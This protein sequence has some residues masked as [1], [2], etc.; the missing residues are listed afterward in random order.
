MDYSY[1]MRINHS[2]NKNYKLY[3]YLL[4]FVAMTFY[5]FFAFYDG[6]V[7]CA[8]TE[9]Y[10]D[11]SIT[12]EFFYSSFLAV[13]RIIFGEQYLLMVVMVQSLLAAYAAWNITV[14]FRTKFELG[15]FLSSV[16]FFI[17]IATSLLNRFVAGRG[18]MYSNS[19]L[20]EGITIPLFL[21]FFRY[22]YEYFSTA[23]KKVLVISGILVWIMIAT[24]KQMYV[25]LFLFFCMMVIVQ[26]M[27]V[28]RGKNLGSFL[29]LRGRL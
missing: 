11:M 22:I 14:Y 29:Y 3:D 19:I 21:L 28:D 18:S 8:D 10:V 4:L 5:L 1:K 16:I 17:P 13:F 23:S 6:A 26:M 25:A 27:A 7:I 9:T 20:T 24:R 15:Y 2:Y 12:R